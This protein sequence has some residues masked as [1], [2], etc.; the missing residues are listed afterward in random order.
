VGDAVVLAYVKNSTAPYDLSASS[1]VQLKSQG[2][3]SEII[4][5]ML[6]H[7]ATLRGNNPPQISSPGG[8]DYNSQRF[9]GPTN[10]VQLA[11]APVTAPPPPA[12]VEPA[13]PTVQAAPAQQAQPQA[14]TVIVQTPPTPAPPP[15]VEV[16][17]V[18]PGPD[19]YWTPGYWHWNGRWM[20]VGGSWG[21]RAGWGP[22]RGWGSY[23]R[24]WEGHHR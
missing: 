10:G 20:W 7:D 1:I 22:H 13:P 16:V 19:Y 23:H 4:A 21:F 12:Q 17:T 5:A 3:S 6:T 11:P 8:P 9:Y 24:G 15:Q 18:A 14:P 2:I